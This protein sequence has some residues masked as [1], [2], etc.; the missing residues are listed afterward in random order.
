MYGNANG[1]GLQTANAVSL[2]IGAA[3]WGGANF[4]ATLAAL[5]NDIVHTNNGAWRVGIVG[6]KQ[7]HSMLVAGGYGDVAVDTLLRTEYPR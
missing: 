4:T 6:M 7:L 2:A 1:D 5:V 3:G